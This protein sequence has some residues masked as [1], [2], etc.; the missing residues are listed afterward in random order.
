[1]QGSA[2][3]VAQGEC[4]CQ[5][6]LMNLEPGGVPTHPMALLVC[7][8]EGLTLWDVRSNTVLST[9]RDCGAPALR[10]VVSV[11]AQVCRGQAPWASALAVAQ[12]GAASVLQYGWGHDTPLFRCAV[13]EPM[14][15]LAASGDG[16]LLA[17]GGASGRL[18]LWDAA[19]GELCREWQAHY[20]ATSCLAFSPCGALLASGGLDGVAHCWDVAA[21]LDVSASPGSSGGGS[22]APPAASVSWSGHTMALMHLMFSPLSGLCGGPAAARLVTCSL[23]RTVR[24]WDVASQRC[25]R[26]ATLPCGASALCSDATG[27]AWYVGCVDGSIHPL[28]GAGGDSAGQ[29]RSSAALLGHTAAVTC[30]VLSPD[31]DKVFSGGDDGTVRVWS[32]ASGQQIGTLGGTGAASSAAAA[33]A[34]AASASAAPAGKRT[35]IAA[36]VLLPTRPPA[37]LEARGGAGGLSLS[38]AAGTPHCPLPLPVIHPLRKHA[39]FSAEGGAGSSSG[40]LAGPRL[41]LLRV[42][43]GLGLGGVDSS[44]EAA[45]AALRQVESH[46]ASAAAAGTQGSAQ[47]GAGAAAAGAAAE[48]QELVALR[49]KVAALEAENAR[50]KAVASKLLDKASS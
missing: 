10:G 9:Y 15:A 41:T 47:E 21:L 39:A 17:G 18:Y 35:S 34:A 5:W 48:T 26:T 36:L 11:P 46:A 31:G 4:Q 1:V 14:C 49:G 42:R 33:A 13:S 43:V 3:G 38:A 37:H 44:E 16:T 12:S 22:G 7:S 40:G 20:K 23:D 27:G 45:L 6:Q 30:L 2:R 24:W 29:P 50:W 28:S 32:V 25:L 8:A 19:T